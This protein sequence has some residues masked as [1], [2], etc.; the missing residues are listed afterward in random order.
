MGRV[1][2][3]ML[4][5]LSA[6]AAWADVALPGGLYQIREGESVRFSLP[7]KS[8]RIDLATAGVL[9]LFLPSPNTLEV[10][11]KRPG[12]CLV[13]IQLADGTLHHVAIQVLEAVSDAGVLKA[14]SEIRQ[15]LATISGISVVPEGPRVVVR[16]TA[17]ISTQQLYRSIIKVYG[18]LVIDQ[19]KFADPAAGPVGEKATYDVFHE[20]FDGFDGDLLL[21]DKGQYKIGESSPHGRCVQ[22]TERYAICEQDSGRPALVMAGS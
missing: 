8:T 13:V 14:A 18:N 3:T 19:V 2:L 7:G 16:G 12:H 20:K 17:P 6:A 11:G 15:N 4:V 21:T 9:E 5:M 10:R 1:L 22:V